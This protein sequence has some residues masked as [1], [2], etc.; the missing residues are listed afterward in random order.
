MATE[1]VTPPANLT[2]LFTDIEASSSAWERDPT[3]MDAAQRRHDAILR[4]AIT[5]H[6]GRVFAT[7]GDGVAAAFARADHA[8]AAA[9]DAQRALLDERWPAA[10]PV[11]VRMGMHT[12]TA[13]ERD[14]DYFGRAVIRAAR[15]MALVDGG[16]IICSTATRR[17]CRPR[18]LV[19]CT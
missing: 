19:I 12:G 10:T 11:R 8:L 13:I 7:A 18:H 14:G 15:L 16:R 5:T 6:E 17:R 4:D 1:Q 3:T 9:V 2:F